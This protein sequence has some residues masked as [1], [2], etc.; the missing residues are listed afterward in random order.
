M[1]LNRFY[2]KMIPIGNKQDG[3]SMEQSIRAGIDLGT[4]V[5]KARIKAGLT[6]AQVAAFSRVGRRFI[7]DLEKGKATAQIG[8]ILQVLSSL[9]LSLIVR[10]REFGRG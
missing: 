1:H 3:G 9:G 7:Y 4:S 5:R 10:P 8:K 2:Y 6:L